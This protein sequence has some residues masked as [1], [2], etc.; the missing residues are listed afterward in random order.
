MRT[1]VV[2]LV[3]ITVIKESDGRLIVRKENNE[4]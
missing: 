3:L 1:H 4:R 2:H